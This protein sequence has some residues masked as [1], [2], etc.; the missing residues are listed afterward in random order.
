M[1]TV[2]S[3]IATLIVIATRRTVLP[4]INIMVGYIVFILGA[5]FILYAR[6]DCASV[7]TPLGELLRIEH[8]L[9]HLRIYAINGRHL[10]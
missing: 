7:I 10:P 1:I 5:P 6:G 9:L 4:N 3:Q 2:L 8:H